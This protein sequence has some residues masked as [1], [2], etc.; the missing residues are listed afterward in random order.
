MRIDAYT[1]TGMASGSLAGS[2]DLRGTLELGGWL[3]LDDATWQGLDDPEASSAGSVSIPSDDVLVAFPDEEPTLPVHAAWHRIYLETGPY[4]LEG[5]L[6][7]MPGFDPGRALARPSGEFLLLRD[8]RLSV[9]ARPDAGVSKADHA[10]INRYTV[11]RV[12]ADLQLGWFFPGAAADPI[13]P[14]GEVA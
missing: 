11:E 7:T 5:E 13:D 3:P 9:T 6:A 1:N 2:A 8:I 10:L 4:T 12:R 14:T